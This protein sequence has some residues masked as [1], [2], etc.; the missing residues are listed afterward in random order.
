MSADLFVFKVNDLFFPAFLIYAYCTPGCLDDVTRR[1]ELLDN[2][3]KKFTMA[4]PSLDAEE[5]L[6]EYHAGILGV[7]DLKNFGLR[8]SR[9]AFLCRGL[10]QSGD[11]WEAP[12]SEKW[13]AAARAG[14]EIKRRE[15]EARKRE[16]ATGMRISHG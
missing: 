1:I 8:Y 6:S 3:T 2:K 16:H 13:Y 14:A 12:R 15:R 9:L 7:S 5:Y 4:V 11:V 10:S